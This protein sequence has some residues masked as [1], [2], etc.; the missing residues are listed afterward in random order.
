MIGC[1][2][3]LARAHDWSASKFID[4]DSLDIANRTPAHL[5]WSVTR[6]N[7][8]K[9][10]VENYQA[11]KKVGVSCEMHFY[12]KTPAS[13]DCLKPATPCTIALEARKRLNGASK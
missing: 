10:L 13:G 6:N 3:Y 12:A 7:A 5:F 4:R 11:L 8:A 9:R 2:L 1:N